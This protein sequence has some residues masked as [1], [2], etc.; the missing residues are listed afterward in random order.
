LAAGAKK[1][2]WTSEQLL[3]NQAEAEITHAGTRYRLRL[4]ALG[5]LILTK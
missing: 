3:G 2:R 5:K 4:T 1:R